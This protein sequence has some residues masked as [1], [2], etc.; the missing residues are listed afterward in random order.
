MKYKVAEKFVSINGEGPLAGQAAAFIRF[1]GCNLR[2]GYCDTAWAQEFD[3][4][5]DMTGE[6]IAEF[7]KKSG[8]YNVTLTGGEPLMREGMEELICA[9]GNIPCHVEIETNGSM[10]ISSLAGVS[11]RPSFTLDYKL[12]GSGMEGAMLLGNYK[13]LQKEDAVKFV[14][15]SKE[16]LL[17]GEEVIREYKLND[18]CRVFFGVVYG[19][20]SL[21]EAAEFIIGR[22]IKGA[23]LQLQMHKYI[24]DPDTRG[25]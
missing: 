21:Q 2:C 11:P 4:G 20:L 15:G 14:A 16:D 24:W 17:R 7:V 22:K 25:V 12:P 13:Y 19:K 3:G 23:A 10:D 6:E 1:C 8:V 5:E 9:L 18:K